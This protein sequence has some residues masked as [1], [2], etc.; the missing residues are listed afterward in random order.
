[1][2]MD[3][4]FKFNQD[5]AQRSI[6][7][8][9]DF[10]KKLSKEQK[11]EFLWIGCSDSRVPANEIC[12]VGAGE[13]FVHRN[14]GNLVVHSD[15]NCLSVVQFAIDV[16]K[17]KHIIVCGH[18][19][20]GGIKAAMGHDSLGLIDNW[21]R[22]VKVIYHRN[23]EELSR[24]SRDQEQISNRLVELNVMKQVANLSWT[25]IV[26]D[27][28]KRGQELSIHG[29]VYGLDDGLLKDLEVTVN[30]CSRVAKIFKF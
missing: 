8:D 20:C 21:L 15:F 16:L 11:P 13:M 26:Q 24:F 2:G 29:L 23:L 5:W 18:Y 12:G 17:V 19:G 1:M 22:Y 30:S 25:T 28:W 10:F 6:Q 9:P 3:R 27:A 4:I 14:V 7:G